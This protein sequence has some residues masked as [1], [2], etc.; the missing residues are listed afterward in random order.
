MPRNYQ[1]AK[2]VMRLYG[3]KGRGSHVFFMCQKA[4]DY[5]IPDGFLIDFQI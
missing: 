2:E 1:Y 3:A 4:E 5:K